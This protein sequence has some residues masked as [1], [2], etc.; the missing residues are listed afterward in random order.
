MERIKEE[1]V[2]DVHQYDKTRD[3]YKFLPEKGL[4]VEDIVEEAEQ[5]VNMTSVKQTKLSHQMIEEQQSDLYFRVCLHY[6]HSIRIQ[7]HE[8]FHGSDPTKSNIFPGVRK[9][10]TEVSLVL[11]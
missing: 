3:F 1:M 7:I 10:E 11:Y 2:E 4:K 6:F 5:Y 9:M 8:L